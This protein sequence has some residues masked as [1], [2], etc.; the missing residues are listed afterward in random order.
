MAT[1]RKCSQARLNCSIFTALWNALRCHLFID[2]RK[3]HF[4]VSPCIHL[5]LYLYHTS[6][7]PR[8]YE[9]K[10]LNL[11]IIDI[12]VTEGGGSTIQINQLFQIEHWILNN[13]IKKKRNEKWKN[14]RY[15]NNKRMMTLFKSKSVNLN[16][17]QENIFLSPNIDREHTKK[18]LK[19]YMLL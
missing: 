2:L 9:H 19:L 4:Y 7:R 17:G 6:L 3:C 10:I 16:R 1:P 5:H 11:I 8:C 15:E 18:G 13:F 12:V 14:T